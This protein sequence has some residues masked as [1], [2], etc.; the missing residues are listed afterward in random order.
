MLLSLLGQHTVHSTG[1]VVCRILHHRQLG[2]N[3]L[4]LQLLEPFVNP[5]EAEG[6]RLDAEFFAKHIRSAVSLKIVM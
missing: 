2:A 4:R 1:Y 3:L 6:S 5:A